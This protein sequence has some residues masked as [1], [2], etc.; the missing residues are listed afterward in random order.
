MV[1]HYPLKVRVRGSSPRWGTIQT[2]AG[3]FQST[4]QRVKVLQ[5]PYLIYHVVYQDQNKGNAFILFWSKIME[6]LD[7]EVNKIRN[8]LADLGCR[9]MFGMSCFELL[10]K[11]YNEI[12]E[13]EKLED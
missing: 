3:Q 9:M 1:T 7:Y 2:V 8:G 11:I 4:P 6:T 13:K 5:L 10:E 12:I